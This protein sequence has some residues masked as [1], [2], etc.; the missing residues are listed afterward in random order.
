MHK[1]LIY[2]EF[3]LET[4]SDDQ[5]ECGHVLNNCTDSKIGEI[6]GIAD[7]ISDLQNN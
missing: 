2:L 3:K 5:N 1:K 6:K 4:S 7:A